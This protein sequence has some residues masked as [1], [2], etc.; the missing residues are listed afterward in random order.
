MRKKLVFL[1]FALA[2][3]AGALLSSFRVEALPHCVTTCCD[4]GRCI[5]CCPWTKCSD[6][7]C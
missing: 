6:L 4:D 2:T 3:A 1:S 7:A 5:T